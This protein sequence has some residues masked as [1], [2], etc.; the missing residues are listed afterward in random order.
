MPE[1]LRYKTSLGNLA[2]EFAALVNAPRT[3]VALARRE[4][5]HLTGTQTAVI[6]HAAATPGLTMHELADLTGMR[7]ST[8][9]KLCQRMVGLGH[10]TLE[11]SDRDG[12]TKIVCLTGDGHDLAVALL[13]IGDDLLDRAL[14]GSSPDN[15]AAAERIMALMV[16]TLQPRPTLAP[17]APQRGLTRVEHEP[18]TSTA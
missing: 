1:P 17:V 12:R 7:A 18:V 3:S 2:F 8:I 4:T 9:S 16:T 15:I 6:W 13:G 14:A 11:R 10:L 5:V